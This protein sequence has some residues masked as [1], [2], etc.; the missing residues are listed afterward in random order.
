MAEIDPKKLKDLLEKSGIERGLKIRTKTN[1]NI[2]NI[3]DPAIY[4]IIFK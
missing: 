3:H 4:C 1:P 2:F